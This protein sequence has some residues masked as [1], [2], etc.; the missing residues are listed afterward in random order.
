MMKNPS[1]IAVIA[2]SAGLLTA[3]SKQESSTPGAPQQAPKAATE[4]QKPAAQVSVPADQ[5]PPEPPD[6]TETPET[7]AQGMIDK[8]S[9]LVT[10]NKYSEAMDLLKK[11]SSMQ[12]TPKQ[13]K[14]VDY[15]TAQVQKAMTGAATSDASQKASDAVGGMLGG[16]NK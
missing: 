9:S 4:M 3:C 14:M 10:A 8:A 1:L 2:L 15:L 13:K 12:L 16:G 6:V 11:L 7:I 5:T